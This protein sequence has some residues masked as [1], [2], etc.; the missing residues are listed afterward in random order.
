MVNNSLINIYLKTYNTTN[1]NG[2]GYPEPERIVSPGYSTM[3]YLLFDP[4][5]TDATYIP[6]N[7]SFFTICLTLNQSDQNT[8]AAASP[9]VGFSDYFSDTLNPSR[10]IEYYY[11]NWTFRDDLTAG[12]YSF[13]VT[14]STLTVTCPI[15]PEF[16]IN[17]TELGNGSKVIQTLERP[18]YSA[19]VQKGAVTYQP[20]I[21]QDAEY[22]LLDNYFLTNRT[23][24]AQTYSFTLQDYTGGQFYK[25]TV[26]FKTTINYTWGN[27]HVEQFGVDNIVYPL[28]Q[29]TSNYKV[30]VSNNISTRDLGQV[31]LK[32]TETNKNIIVTRPDLSDTKGKWEDLNLSIT[33]NYDYGQFTCLYYD[34]NTIT[35][36]E[37]WVYNSTSNG[38][39][40][41]YYTNSTSASGSLTYQALNLSAPYYG[42]CKVTDALGVR[43]VKELFNFRNTG[44]IYKGFDLNLPNNLMGVSKATFYKVVALMITIVFGGLFS[45]MTMGTGAIVATITMSFFNYIGWLD[46]P[47][48][49]VTLLVFLAIAFKLS[50]N[51]GGV[52]T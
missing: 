29:N 44:A 36:A 14:N 40:Q 50:E 4:N 48:W 20:R 47:T 26:A 23:D 31:Y 52:Q 25:S 46:V 41:D 17:L 1:P 38:L 43:E 34:T 12:L 37:F 42:V 49:F 30:V 28:L 13:L 18:R 5:N 35:V 15:Y 51:R 19:V 11:R 6:T 45:M 9:P 22:F 27:V 2:V 33:S 32:G 8:L 16:K 24:T 10:F 3:G 7:P 39:V 21:R